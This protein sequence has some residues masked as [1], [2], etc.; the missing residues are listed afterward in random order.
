MDSKRLE[1]L[2]NL[3]RRLHLALN[4]C[5]PYEFQIRQRLL[6]LSLT[7]FILDELQDYRVAQT[8]L[9]TSEASQASSEIR[10]ASP[11]LHASSQ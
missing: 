4:I 1:R 10:D 9:E 6:L 5:D 7:N 3:E 8:M 2:E 11:S